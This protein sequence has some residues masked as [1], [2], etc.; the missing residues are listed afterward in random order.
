MTMGNIRCGHCKGY[1]DSIAAVKA[2][3][4]IKVAVAAK[5]NPDVPAVPIPVRPTEYQLSEIRRLRL[6]AGL[7]PHI[8]HPPINSTAADAMID[9]LQKYIAKPEDFLPKVEVK[10]PTAVA[11]STWPDVESGHYAIVVDEVVKFYKVNKKTKGKWAGY[12]F[13]DAQASDDYWPI[14]NPA[15]RRAILDE[16]ARDPKAARVRYAKELNRCSRCNRTLTDETSRARGLGPECA[17]K[18]GF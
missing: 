14:K 10:K 16:I 3:S 13:V 8:P 7:D 6:K 5:A 1:H 12:T 15:K 2:C 17:T 11:P 18:V 4:G 9:T